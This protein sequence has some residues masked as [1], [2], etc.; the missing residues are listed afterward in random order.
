MSI[1]PALVE[2]TNDDHSYVRLAGLDTIISILTLL[3]SGTLLRM[4]TSV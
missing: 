3:D 2:L 1:L 4:L